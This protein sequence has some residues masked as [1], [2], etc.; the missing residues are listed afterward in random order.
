MSTS[1]PDWRHRLLNIKADDFARSR[2]FENWTRFFA[3]CEQHRIIPS[4]GVVAS[5]L[6]GQNETD[7]ALTAALA[8][9][10]RI[11]IWNHSDSHADYRTLSDERIAEDVL[12]AQ[13]RIAAAF[14]T[15]PAS[16]G[17]PFNYYDARTCDV[18]DGLGEFSI[19]YFAP[20]RDPSVTVL[21]RAGLFEPEISTQTRQPLRDDPKRLDK[22][23]SQCAGR[24]VMQVHPHFWCER[25][26][27][28]FDT[29][30]RRLRAERFVP[31][32]C[33]E[34]ADHDRKRMGFHPRS[35]GAATRADETAHAA[36]R[37]ALP[38]LGLPDERTRHFLAHIQSGAGPIWSTLRRIGFDRSMHKADYSEPEICV[39]LG[40]GPGNWAWPMLQM[41]Q[42]RRYIGIDR[43]RALVEV[44]RLI[45]RDLPNIAGRWDLRVGDA[46]ATA[47]PDCSATHVIC[48]N[49]LNF[50]DYER[51]FIE[52]ARILDFSR[53]CFIGQQRQRFIAYDILSNA[54]E[55]DWDAA[56]STLEQF[57]IHT[58]RR[59]AIHLPGPVMQHDGDDA[60]YRC[61][62][63]VGL[64][65]MLRD[66]DY[67]TNGPT[68]GG[69]SVYGGY[70]A[71]KTVAGTNQA[72]AL[73]ERPAI[74]PRETME[75]WASGFPRTMLRGVLARPELLQT[76]SIAWCCAFAV[77]L[78]PDLATQRD[79][80]ADALT[81]ASG[82]SPAETLFHAI[83]A[84]QAGDWE[85][86][87]DLFAT[88]WAQLDPVLREAGD[89]LATHLIAPD[90]NTDL[91]Q[92]L[93]AIQTAADMARSQTLLALRI[94]VARQ[95]AAVIE[96]M[97]G[98]ESVM[99]LGS[100]SSHSSF[101]G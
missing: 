100:N 21:D 65:I 12:L 80:L 84:M 10:E 61:F 44:G 83:A 40:C 9:A 17:Y 1:G 35:R 25:S 74:G 39:D 50:V 48:N 70:L 4:V 71:L 87:R 86:A 59:Q 24:L 57:V 18:L 2:N 52:A 33:A 46:L 11:E 29:M 81:Q 53:Y 54:R 5:D 20:A 58:A 8:R 6:T 62:G 45:L 88:P 14:G 95:D 68:L 101:V 19:S 30:L 60:F 22:A 15:R 73:Q 32:T 37:T 51:L 72:L 75:L 85:P 79:A 64:R 66:I 41:E 55:G 23:L 94:G 76:P 42:S 27:A 69:E 98:D 97:L 38:G 78:I 7:L 3:I 93:P 31:L 34:F 77:L 67:D 82:S 43:D 99:S 49:M 90:A 92:D 56:R 47:L 28:A 36:A 91:P 13:E 16:F 96:R 89:F 26:F 63:Y